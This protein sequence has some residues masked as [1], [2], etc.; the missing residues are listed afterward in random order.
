MGEWL[1]RYF[2]VDDVMSLGGYIVVTT[3]I[4]LV[5]PTVGVEQASVLGGGMLAIFWLASPNVRER[6]RERRPNTRV[7]FWALVAV[8]SAILA[9]R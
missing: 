5:N 4:R 7:V 6:N 2:S 1:S 8:V 3:V 9:M